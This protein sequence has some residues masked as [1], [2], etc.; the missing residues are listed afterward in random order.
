MAKV[1]LYKVVRH[2]ANRMI[3]TN[4]AALSKTDDTQEYLTR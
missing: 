2:V 1:E 3:A 4:T